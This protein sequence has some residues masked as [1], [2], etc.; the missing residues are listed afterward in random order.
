MNKNN[1]NKK[2]YIQI[3]NN[4]LGLEVDLDGGTGLVKTTL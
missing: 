3:S 4:H 1:D 2:T